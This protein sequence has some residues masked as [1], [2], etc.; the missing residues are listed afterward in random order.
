VEVFPSKLDYKSDY[1]SLLADVQDILAGLVLEYLQSTFKLGFTT[2]STCATKLE[3]ITLLRHLIDDLERSLRYIAEHPHHGLTRE[4]LPTRVERLRRPDA[5]VFKM[6]IQ[7]KGMGPKCQMPSGLVL[8]SK[9]PEQ[10]ARVTLNTPEHRWLASQLTRIRQQLAQINHEE[11][12]RIRKDQEPTPRQLRTLE[13]VA[14]LQNRIAALQKLEPLAEAAGSVPSGFTSLKL[15]ASPGYREAYRACLVLLL[16]LRVA[17]GPIGLSVKE[18]HQLYEYWCYLALVRLLSEITGEKMPASRLLSVEQNGLHVQLQ[19]G[20]TQTV[21]FSGKANRSVELTYNPR[22]A[23]DPFI[24]AQRPDVLLT[25]RDPD[26]PTIKLVL[27]AKYRIQSDADYIKQIGSPGPPASAI[28]VLHRYRDAIL[29]QS[30]ATGSRSDTLKRTVI[31]GAALFPYRDEVDKFRG[32][33]LWTALD[34]LG[35]GALPFLPSEIRYVDEWLRTVL[36]RGGWSTAER[37]IPYVSQ[38]RLRLSQSAA[39]EAVL[40]GVLRT[41]AKEHLDWIKQNR[42]YYA[43]LT[44]SQPRQLISRW[45]AIY[46][47]ASLRARGAITHVAI[48]RNISVKERSL[49]QTPWRS[50]RES[51]EQCVVYELGEFCELEKPIEN[52][53]PDGFGQR[54]SK[55][56]WTSRLGLLR[57]S[58]LRELFLETEPEWRLYEQLRVADVDFTLTPGPPKLEDDEDPRGRTWFVIRHRKVQYRGSAGFLIRVEGLVDEYLANI[59]HVVERVLSVPTDVAVVIPPVTLKT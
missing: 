22:Y 20:K 25:L 7:G 12:N 34:R 8:H 40:I 23:G 38:E 52:R 51:K 27:D 24:F 6:V 5:A 10:R 16:G 42:R 35:I 44:E 14:A 36:H 56:R 4:R 21:V 59:E 9:L 2:H 48:V 57:A 1:D 19:K 46:S 17:G 32:S 43:P 58:E 33:R 13:E 45:I 55:N 41:N 11:R 15:Q 30:G 29:E 39:Y 53:G 50:S 28:N 37:S 47:P 49:I 3:W 54:F 18:I 31:E 26:W